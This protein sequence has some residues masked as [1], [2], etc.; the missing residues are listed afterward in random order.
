MG[1][2]FRIKAWWR[3]NIVLMFLTLLAP[4]LF[5][6]AGATVSSANESGTTSSLS[7]RPPQYVLMAFDG[8]LNLN[9]WE[10]SL[11]FATSMKNENKPVQ[12]TYFLS[13]VYFLNDHVQSKYN[14]PH[15]GPG[16]SA[17][18]FGGS[19]HDIG[20]RVA[21][22]NRAYQAGHEL[23]SHA[24]GHYDGGLEKWT[25]IDWTSEFYQFW[26]L[27]FN[28]FAL[29]SIH[30]EA[31][32]TQGLLFDQSEIV[33]FRAPQLGTNEDMYLALKKFGFKYDTS[34]DSQPNYWPSKSNLGI[35]NFPLADLV[36][37]GTGK[38]TLSMD[39]NFYVSQSGAEPDLIHKDL[40]RKQMLETYLKYFQDNYN[41][42]RAPIHIGHHFSPWNGGIYWQAEQEFAEK[43]CGIPE[44]RCV[45]YKNYMN[46]L[47]EQKASDLQ[48][49]RFG[50]FNHLPPISLTDSVPVQTVPL[51]IIQHANGDLMIHATVANDEDLQN[52]SAHF[53][54]NHNILKKS[55]VGINEVR[56][57][58]ADVKHS[59]I[60]AHLIEKRTGLEVSRAT[61]HL[62]DVGTDSEHLENEI[63]EDRARS[64]DLPEAHKEMP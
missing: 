11:N 57:L 13:G 34:R 63:L 51:K 27:I 59:R 14:A 31:P 15:H 29:N 47:E 33:G 25:L 2:W 26:N 21:E 54:V 3:P 50:K 61:Q 20:P 1:S 44:V 24:N 9:F 42:N 23:G 41:G 40:Y 62:R 19:V 30:P 8:S 10:E 64:G 32:F 6:T 43:V 36:I 18:G 55:T 7:P 60:T 28:V 49:Y 5:L 12:F 16:H 48:N 39:Y 35:W 46:W 53:T 37:V 17:I 22:V 45:T 56:S 52:Y 4:G 58:S 38:K